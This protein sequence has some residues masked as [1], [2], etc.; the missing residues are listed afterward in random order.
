[1]VSYKHALAFLLKRTTAS[2]KGGGTW[3]MR[4][5]RPELNVPSSLNAK[6][7]KVGDPSRKV[8]IA[9]GSKFSAGAGSPSVG[10]TLPDADLNFV[11]SLGGPFADQGPT[12]FTR[13]WNR[14]RVDG[15]GGTGID[16]RIFWARHG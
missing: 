2:V 11:G 3:G 12:R 15:N 14:D 9:D 16:C 10:E 5:T 7:S 6:L 4:T 8:F 13:A 1:M